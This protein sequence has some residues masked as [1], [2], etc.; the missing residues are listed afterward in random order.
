MN[1]SPPKPCG[2]CGLCCKLPEIE[3]LGKPHG[4]WCETYVEG[5][6]CTIRAKRPQVCASFQCLWTLDPVLGERWRP[7]KAKFVLISRQHQLLVECDP[8]CP[9]AWKAEPYYSHIKAWS[10]RESRQFIAVLV[11]SRGCMIYVF[12]E[13]DID[14]GPVRPGALVDSGYEINDG[15]RVPYARYVEP[16]PGRL[17]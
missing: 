15:L 12:P 4:K 5:Q 3:V 10:R 1:L 17:N 13:A 11:R 16:A 8:D 9:D 7:D 14:L 2:P 6:G